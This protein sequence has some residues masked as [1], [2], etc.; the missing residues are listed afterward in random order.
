M[1]F[2]ENYSP[3]RY[4]GGKN[5]L[6]NYV[7]DLINNNHMQGCT[8]IEPYAGGAAVA[9]KLLIDGHVNN[10]IINDYDRS[11]YAFWHSVIYE[12]DKLCELIQ[13][14]PINIE[15]WHQ[16]KE[17]Q[18][19]K[20]DYSLLELGFSTFYLNRTN[21]SGVI[22][23][24]VIGGLNQNGN[25][26]IDCRFNKNQLIE[27]IRKIS[28]FKEAI[29]LYNLDTLELINTVINNLENQC[30]IFFDPPYYKKGST[31]YVN[32]YNHDDHVNLMNSIS[33]IRNHKWIVT[34]DNVSE[35]EFLYKNF[36]SITY[37][38]KYTVQKKYIGSEIM[39]FSNNLLLNDDLLK[40]TI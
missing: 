5:K 14:T 39:V 38:L 27:K 1:S 2:L 16:L 40:I 28:E 3:L 10:I 33:N 23:A 34:Y 7:F 26:L 15:I 35:I 17:I 20:Y 18:K 11:I 37:S 31:L 19:H 8:Y 32:Y 36:R 24:G 4:P 21:R 13:N 29:R 6:A 25:Y 12:T 9:L 30:F 22:K